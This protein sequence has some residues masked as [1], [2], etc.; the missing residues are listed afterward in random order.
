LLLVALLLV[1][2]LLVALLWVLHAL[3]LVG[4]VLDG[5]GHAEPLLLAELGLLVLLDEIARAAWATLVGEST[6]GAKGRT[7][8]RAE[9]VGHAVALEVVLL[10]DLA[11]LHHLDDPLAAD[12]GQAVPGAALEGV[13]LV[14]W[15]EGVP[16]TSMLK[17]LQF[18]RAPST[19]RRWC[20]RR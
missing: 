1:S 9:A 2:L 18:W 14:E 16:R 10:A 13:I 12:V 4:L 6:V 3:D 17:K 11:A 15:R 19:C 7:A 8:A 20:W 5:H